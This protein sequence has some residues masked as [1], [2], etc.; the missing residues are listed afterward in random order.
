M[1]VQ[2]LQSVQGS[3]YKRVFLAFPGS[4]ICLAAKQPYGIIASPDFGMIVI[5]I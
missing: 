3:F 2:I 1:T 4:G 5:I